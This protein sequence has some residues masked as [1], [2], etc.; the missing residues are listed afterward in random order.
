MVEPHRTLGLKTWDG[1]QDAQKCSNIT[2]RVFFSPLRNTVV[3]RLLKYIQMSIER[4]PSSKF[5]E[6][7]PLLLTLRWGTV[8]GNCSALFTECLVESNWTSDLVWQRFNLHI[9]SLLQM[10]G[11]NVVKQGKRSS[12]CLLSEMFLMIGNLPRLLSRYITGYLN[13]YS[14]MVWCS[15]EIPL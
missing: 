13:L 7:T 6:K 5:E 10:R 15:R 3:F 4:A 9:K 14:I 1:P 2:L 8:S 12:C 11:V